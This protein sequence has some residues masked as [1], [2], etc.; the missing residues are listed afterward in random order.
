MAVFS[1]IPKTTARWYLGRREYY[2][3]THLAIAGLVSD[4]TAEW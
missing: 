2:D 1:S 3:E 4:L